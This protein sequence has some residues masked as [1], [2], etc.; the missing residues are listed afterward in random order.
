MTFNNRLSAYIQLTRLDK[1]IGILLLL[2]PTLWGLWLAADGMPDLMILIIFVLGTVL[3][4]SAGCA[5]NDF[6]D[7]RIDPHVSRTRNRPLATGIITSR[8]ALLIAAGLSLCAFLLILPLN[9]L[10]I[11]LSVPALFLAVSYPFTKRFFSMPQAY[12]G[13]AFSFGIPMAFAAQTGT[14]PPLAWLLVLGNLFWVIAYD[15]EYA[16]VDRSD[17]LKIG[18]Q[19]SAITLGRFDVAAVMLCHAIFLSTLMYIGIWL[20]R[21]IGFYLGLLA[22]L[23]LII[24]QYTMIREREPARCFQAFLHNNRVGAVIFIGI[25]L[26]SLLRINP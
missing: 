25:L 11:Q 12:L 7:R 18:I 16:M 3:M 2:W 14:V 22:A 26:D 5:I 9:L 1:P 19:T 23:G 24:M 21:G 13:I 8:E 4:R 17:D 6:A 15:T 20:Q 10:T